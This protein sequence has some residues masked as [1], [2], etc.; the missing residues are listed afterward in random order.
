MHHSL[1]YSSISVT[2]RSV[3]AVARVGPSGDVHSLEAERAREH[4]EAG[5]PLPA[6]FRDADVSDINGAGRTVELKD[7]PVHGASGPLGRETQT[8]LLRQPPTGPEST[9]LWRKQGRHLDPAFRARRV[10]WPRSDPLR[11]ASQR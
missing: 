10:A 7:R 2:R 6:V 8:N 11:R 9:R 3:L 5:N 4:F 1:P